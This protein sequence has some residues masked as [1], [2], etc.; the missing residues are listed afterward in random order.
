MVTKSVDELTIEDLLE[1]F[2]EELYQFYR[3]QAVTDMRALL[4]ML[5]TEDRR[6]WRELRLELAMKVEFDCIIDRMRRGEAVPYFRYETLAIT[7]A[8]YQS[9]KAL[10]III[11]I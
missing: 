1:D 11:P 9:F 5:E 4:P 8:K 7:H 3:N 10:R 6:N 2:Q